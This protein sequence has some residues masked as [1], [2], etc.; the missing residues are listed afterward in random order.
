M[1]D[2]IMAGDCLK[3]L[4]A[5]PSGCAR[6]V[7][8]DPP[9]NTGF[10]YD[11]YQDRVAKDEYLA[12]TFDWLTACRRVLSDDGSIYV[13]IGLEYQAEVKVEMGR[14]GFH[15]RD[16]V[17]W[18][19]TFGP[20]QQAKWTPSWVAI[21]YFC[22]SPTG[23]VWNPDAVR[24]PSARQLKYGDKRAN[25]SGKVPDNAWVLLPKEYEGCFMPGQ[26][27]M[28]ESRV[29][30][31]FKERGHHPCQMPA[32]VMDRIIL[33]SSDVGDLVVDPFS[34]SGTTCASAKALGRRY[35]GVE[36]SEG[37]AGAS[38]IRLE[39]VIGGSR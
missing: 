3:E 34:G 28:L 27:A 26:N 20:C 18:H 23:R 15:W 13:A 24:V 12:W 2:R 36:L 16:T 30:G 31:T 11:A 35:F 39:S 5:L 8:T 29:A 7:A 10:K 19:Y 6:L 25:A 37:Y 17:C 9:F 38:R 4:S 22:V 14:A 33:A 21:H 1:F 32:A